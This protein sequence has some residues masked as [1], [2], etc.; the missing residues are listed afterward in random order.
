MQMMGETFAENQLG[1]DF[2]QKVLTELSIGFPEGWSSV[3]MGPDAQTLI[4]S[5]RG[6]VAESELVAVTLRPTDAEAVFPGPFLQD[7]PAQYKAAAYDFLRAVLEAFDIHLSE[8]V[9]QADEAG[10]CRARATFRKGRTERALDVRPSDALALARRMSA[11]VFADEAVMQQ[12]KV[13]ENGLPCVFGESLEAMKDELLDSQA[14]QDLYN[15]AWDLGLCP[16]EGRDT[17]RLEVDEAAGTLRISVEGS[18][19]DPLTLPLEMHRRGLSWVR[20]LCASL[21]S[22]HH[23]G[24]T[25]YRMNTIVH[26]STVTIR[27]SPAGAQG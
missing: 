3:S 4:L 6:P 5:T 16:E 8:V 13:G 23:C 7:D 2:T 21:N 20:R 1:D 14:G 22:E 17:V 15:R 24:T 9:L 12:R 18:S 26:D 19:A 25:T 10:A 11:P 27:F